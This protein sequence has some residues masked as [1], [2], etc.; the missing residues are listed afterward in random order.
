MLFEGPSRSG[1]VL[2]QETTREPGKWRRRG[3]LLVRLFSFYLIRPLQ[4]GVDILMAA[5]GLAFLLRFG[6]EF[7]QAAPFDETL[8][9]FLVRYMTDPP[10]GFVLGA[11]NEV[12][13]V[14]ATVRMLAPLALSLLTWIFRPAVIGWFKRVRLR[15][16]EPPASSLFEPRNS[17]WYGDPR[18]PTPMYLANVAEAGE[19]RA[20]EAPAAATRPAKASSISMLIEKSLQVVGRYELLEELGSG[21]NTGVYKALDL[22]IGRTVAMKM[23]FTEGMDAEQKRLQ[24]KWLNREARTAGKLLHPGIVSV[25]DIGEDDA[26]NPYI[27]MEFVDGETLEE[28]LGPNHRGDPLDFLRR[29]DIAIELSKTLEFAHSRGVIHRDI[30]PSNVLIHSDG[31]PKIVDFGIAMLTDPNA[32]ADNRVPGTPGFVAPE[33]LTGSAA[34]HS[35]DLFSLGVL[36]YWMFTGA[37]PF[38][39]RTVTEITHNTAHT[40]P[41]PV[42]SRNWALPELLDAVLRKCLAKRKQE[43]YASGAELARDLNS[44]RENLARSLPPIIT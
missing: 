31:Q 27:V 30:K 10:L 5:Y 17:R 34:S 6:L 9:A 25:F 19:T 11:I 18:E 44:L 28:A 43:R 23:V 41:R 37:L 8:P 1:H 4:H 38:D 3:R 40:T 15:W 29:L 33:L 16:E 21:A 14:S 42:R 13:P 12:S 26:G 24:K 2:I 39:G 32:A 20:A 35:S 22:E 7:P 36:I